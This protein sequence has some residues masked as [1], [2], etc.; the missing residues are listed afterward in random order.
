[1]SPEDFLQ[2]HADLPANDRLEALVQVLRGPQGC[3]WDRSQTAESILDCLIEE[4]HELKTALQRGATEEIHAEL[5]DLLFTQTFLLHTLESQSGREQAA[6]R[7]TRKMIARHPH[8]FSP[9]SIPAESSQIPRQ[10][11]AL[12]AQHEG[13]RA[14]W[15]E[16][17]P[18]SLSAWRKANKVLTRVSQAGFRYPQPEQAWQKV[19]EEW[20]ELLEALEGG[21]L[22]HQQ[23]EFGDLLL[24]LATAALES[25]IAA[26]PA[27][28]AAIAKLADRLQQLEQN[29]GRPLHELSRTE[30]VAGYRQLKANGLKAYFQHCG[31]ALWPAAVE[32]AVHRAARRVARDGFMAAMQLAQ[33]REELRQRL[34]RLVEAQADQ[35]V[36]VPNVSTATLGVAYCLDWKPGDRV[37]LGR[38][39]FPANTVAWKQAAQLFR[40]E[41]VEFDED[42][43]RREPEAGWRELEELLRQREPRLLALSAVSYWSGFRLD[44]PRLAALCR[45][46]RCRLFLDGI[47]ALGTVPLTWVEGIDFLAGGSHKGL[48]APEGAGFL[49]VS[50]SARRSWVPRLAG[51]LSLPEPFHFLSSSEASQDPNRKAPRPHDPRTL[52]SGT[53]N[54]LGY[55]GLAAALQALADGGGPAQVQRWVQP[56][57]DLLETALTEDG[58]TSLRA[59]HPEGRSAILSFAPPE[60]TDLPALQQGLAQQ[61]IHVGIPRGYLRLG[62]HASTT[63]AEVQALLAA[64]P[65]QLQRA[66]GSLR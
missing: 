62:C 16:D 35:V 3:P 49:V 47:Q 34:A 56:L 4:A 45:A 15:D 2:Q 41:V 36:L 7:V 51:W 31:V 61:G 27:L 65:E 59:P 19:Q 46:S 58:W 12:K 57:H 23:A 25:G 40:L 60:G 1:M 50:E 52:E 29:A 42:R 54:S 32:R 48:M 6:E 55:A 30:M 53:Q 38:T 63:E 18:A 20:N 64:M 66:R 44:V 5:G 9:S 24:A 26:E 33:E 8:V 10:W 17:L 21:S 13:G 11:Q 39:E 22:E 28:E 43:L 37:L 14:R